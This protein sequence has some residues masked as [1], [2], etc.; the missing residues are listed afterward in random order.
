M[1]APGSTAGRPDFAPVRLTR[2][3]PVCNM[4]RF[5]ILEPATSLFGERGVVRHWG[6]IGTAGRIRTDWY[7]DPHEAEGAFQNLLRAKQRRGYAPKRGGH[8]GC[9]YEENL[10][11]KIES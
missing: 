11:T 6:R 3:D 9:A 2:S 4:N 8:I 7:D 10:L 1:A 5:Y